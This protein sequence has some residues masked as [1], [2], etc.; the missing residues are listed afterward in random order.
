MTAPEKRV[1]KRNEA[2]ELKRKRREEARQDRERM[3]N[4]SDGGQK[5]KKP[6]LQK[7]IKEL[8]EKYQNIGLKVEVVG[9]NSG[10]TIIVNGRVELLTLLGHDSYTL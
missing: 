7:M 10:H 5:F 2:R 1:K 4:K 8:E 6:V 9:K 3:T